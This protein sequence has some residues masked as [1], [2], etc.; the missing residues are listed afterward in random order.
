M[1]RNKRS[2]YMNDRRLQAASNFIKFSPLLLRWR[3][4]PKWVFL[5]L[6]V[7]GFLLAIVFA[8]GVRQLN[9]P[10]ASAAA[11]EADSEAPFALESP[12]A[13]TSSPNQQRHELTYEEWKALLAQEAK[14]VAEQ[15]PERLSV[16]VGDSISLWFPEEFLS[17]DRTWLNQGISGE[18]S[19]GLLSRLNLFDQT[20]PE[21]IFIMI[22]IND[23]L[24]GTSELT[25][26]ENYRL[27][28][29]DLKATHPQAQIVVQ[30][31][32]PH[33]AE[34]ATWEG[35]DRLM[36]LP[37][38]KIQDLNRQIETVAQEEDVYFLDLYSLFADD[39]GKLRMALSTDGLH[40]NKQGFYVWSIA[41]RVYERQV[42]E[43]EPSFAAEWE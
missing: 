41:L 23:L 14:V 36:N 34:Q 1:L 17:R 40:L 20:R 18:T 3:L 4:L 7:N 24:R 35:R 19:A 25:I 31:I 6:A 2:Q 10:T 22:G 43:A 29:D 15:Q 13:T 39:A 26:L 16:L 9:A 32:L 37:N 21:T 5:S 42:L 8:L 11:S 12:I 38:Q 33:A 28:I 27:M 30:S